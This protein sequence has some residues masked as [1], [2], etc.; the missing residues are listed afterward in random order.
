MSP[1]L[2]KIDSN[3]TDIENRKLDIWALGILAYELFFGKR[4]FEAFSLD[5]LSQM[6]DR[7]IYFIDL[8]LTKEKKISKEFFIFLNKC[9]QKDPIN[10]ANILEL[11]ECDFL[12]FN[13]DLSYSFWKLN[14]AIITNKGYAKFPINNASS[15]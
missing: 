8:N 6:F 5:E 4:P 14:N 10:R 12:N 9:L 1:E 11:K 3:L 7:G 15:N 13:I 2:F